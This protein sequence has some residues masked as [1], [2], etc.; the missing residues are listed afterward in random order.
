M[1]KPSNP[2]GVEQALRMREMFQADGYKVHLD[3]GENFNISTNR[4]T[5]ARIYVTSGAFFR[6]YYFYED[7]TYFTGIN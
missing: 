2:A 7:G 3:V 6:G 5:V 1:H 4:W